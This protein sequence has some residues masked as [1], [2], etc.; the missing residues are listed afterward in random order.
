MNKIKY[1]VFLAIFVGS[2]FYISGCEENPTS[3]G[4]NYIPPGD[5]IGTALLDSQTDSMSITSYTKQK[6]INCY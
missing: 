3:L 1:V 2:L 4:L 5:T 6:F